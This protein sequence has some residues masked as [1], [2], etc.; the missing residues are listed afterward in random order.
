MDYDLADF[1]DNIESQ[2]A[3]E[4]DAM[5]NLMIHEEEEDHLAQYQYELLIKFSFLY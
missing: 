2:F 3:D 4:E 5:G 1:Y